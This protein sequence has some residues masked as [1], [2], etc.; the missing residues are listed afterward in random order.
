MV[1]SRMNGR[2]HVMVTHGSLNMCTLTEE[3]DIQNMII[4]RVDCKGKIIEEDILKAITVKNLSPMAF[5]QT[6]DSKQENMDGVSAGAHVSV[7][8][9]VVVGIA[10]DHSQQQDRN[11]GG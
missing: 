7:K 11:R 5:K 9:G 10:L 2:F 4:V 6:L 1:K 3:D 8:D